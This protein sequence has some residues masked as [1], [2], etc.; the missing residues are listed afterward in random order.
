M[1][2]R[3]KRL[4][5]RDI[6]RL[7]GVSRSTVSLVIN[8]DARISPAT[9]QR[10]QRVITRAGF[11]PNALARGLARR[12]PELVAVVMPRISSHLF[13]DVYF[14]EA[15]SGISDELVRRGRRMLIEIARSSRNEENRCLKLFREHLIEGMLVIGTLR[16]DPWVH[17][18]VRSGK[19]VLLVNSAV[20]RGVSILADNFNGTR[21]LIAR[22]AA[23]GHR[24]IGYIRGLES[25]TVGLER[26]RGFRAGMHEAGLRVETRW[27]ASGD[28]SESSGREAMLQLLRRSSLPTAVFAANDVMAVGALSVL[29][30]RGVAVPEEMTV[31]GADDVRLAAY[32]TPPLTTLRQPMYEIGRLATQCLLEW[33]EGARPKSAVVPTEVVMRASA[34]R[35]RR[36]GR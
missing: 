1:A 7:S 29:R 26:S 31:V 22:L 9:R 6:A 5:I 14:S 34:A 21:A 19:P 15:L 17:E 2:I 30:E 8:R 33:T 10:V 13:S 12:R 3:G 18:L 28:F 23:L 27:V 11:E 4:T 16:T 32:V 35:P 25:T 20:P 24:K 36:A